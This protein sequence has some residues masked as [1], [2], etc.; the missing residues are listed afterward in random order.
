[1]AQVKELIQQSIGSGP[2]LK[3]LIHTMGFIPIIDRN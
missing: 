3:A 2:I 1:M